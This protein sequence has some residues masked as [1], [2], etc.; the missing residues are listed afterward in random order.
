M[1]SRNGTSCKCKHQAHKTTTTT[2]PVYEYF[3][4]KGFLLTA[5]QAIQTINSSKRRSRHARLSESKSIHKQ[6]YYVRLRL[7]L[8]TVHTDDSPQKFKISNYF[9]T[10]WLMDFSG[11]LVPNAIVVILGDLPRTSAW[12][13]QSHNAAGSWS[14]V[15]CTLT[16][17]LA[18][19]NVGLFLQ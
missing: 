17:L 14:I 13:R 18:K 12:N 15:V 10:A 5:L 4:R 16:Q 9:A 7:S 2:S 1:S 8:S 11:F 3:I 19:L 6:Y